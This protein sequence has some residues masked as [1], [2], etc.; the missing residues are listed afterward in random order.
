MKWVR[1]ILL[2]ALLVALPVGVHLFVSRNSDSVS[3]HYLAGTID[4]VEIWLALL[5]SFA[6][7]VL[8]A[9]LIAMLRGARL[10]MTARRYR[11]AA[12][13]LE[14]EVHQLRNLPLTEE[15]EG[16]DPGPV[17]LAAVGGLERGS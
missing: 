16:D 5:A 10:R 15:P 2:I 17:D 3:V 9:S 1:R 11:R 6:G 8:V 12:R 13:E 7:G 4:G 14:S